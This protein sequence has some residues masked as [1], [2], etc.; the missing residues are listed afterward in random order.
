MET[1]KDALGALKKDEKKEPA[2]KKP[3]P[4]KGLALGGGGSRGSYTVGVLKAFEQAGLKFNLVSGTSIGALVGA[5]YVQQDFAKVDAFMDNFQSGGVVSHPFVFPNQYEARTAKT[6]QQFMGIYT[7]GGPSE[8]P[9]RKQYL[10]VFNFDEF[11]ASPIDFA[12]LSWN[13]TRNEPQVFFK[14]NM[15]REDV[16]DKLVSS[17]AYFPAFNLQ[18]IDGDFLID[19]GYCNY[20]LGKVAKEMG[21]QKLWLVGLHNPDEPMPMVEE[22]VEL[23]VR[24][25][26]RLAYYMNFSA[27]ILRQQVMQGYLEGLKY[28]DMAP[29]YIYTFYKEDA[30]LLQILSDVANRILVKRNISLDMKEIQHGFSSLLGYEPGPLHN[31]Y[32]KKQYAGL[33][34]EFLGLVA[35]IDIY[36]QYHITEFAGQLLKTFSNNR[37]SLTPD[38]AQHLGQEMNQAGAEDLI[39]FFHSAIQAFGVNLPDEF[40]GVMNKFKSVYYLALAWH[41][42][43]HFSLAIK[44]IDRL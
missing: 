2:A 15:T 27:P 37:V 41:V 40:Q 20:P 39:V 9:L 29:G 43:D 13:L 44:L 31:T 10:E 16:L 4:V 33:L 11:K 6:P 23:A 26:L 34:L 1:I 3:E 38:A 25:I 18:Q 35:D 17:T 14:K 7:K 30:P 19:G 28:L 21:A 8:A 36:K 22:G 5:V 42:L 32:M 12:C 24:P